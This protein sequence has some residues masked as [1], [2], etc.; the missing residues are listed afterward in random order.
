[1]EGSYTKNLRKDILVARIDRPVEATYISPGTY[2]FLLPW[3]TNFRWESRYSLGTFV[4]RMFRVTFRLGLVKEY[5][6]LRYFLWVTA[7]YIF[8]KSSE[9][10]LRSL[11]RRWCSKNSDSIVVTRAKAALHVLETSLQ[12]VCGDRVRVVRLN[13]TLQPWDNFVVWDRKCVDVETKKTS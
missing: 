5:V 13:K 8:N 12:A 6:S 4:W 11:N 3:R 7:M 1:M 2:G 9:L 10:V